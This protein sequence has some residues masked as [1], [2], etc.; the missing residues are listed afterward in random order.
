M[1][2]EG[3][4]TTALE[5]VL[6]YKKQLAN[7]ST[8]KQRSILYGIPFTTS[9]VCYPHGTYGSQDLQRYAS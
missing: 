4:L 7:P 1:A 5:R 6:S 9:L 2:L 3:G 8:V